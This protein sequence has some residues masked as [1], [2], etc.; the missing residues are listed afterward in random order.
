MIQ[1]LRTAWFR[2]QICYIV[3]FAVWGNFKTGMKCVIVFTGPS[4]TCC[5]FKALSCGIVNIIRE[6][7]GEAE[8][9]ETNKNWK[10]N[11]HT[12]LGY[13][14]VSETLFQ[15][16]FHSFKTHAVR[17]VLV[18]APAAKR[19]NALFVG[20]KWPGFQVCFSPGPIWCFRVSSQTSLVIELAGI[21]LNILPQI[22]G[23]VISILYTEIWRQQQRETYI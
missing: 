1:M 14:P 9:M 3:F 10:K 16:L 18:K 11:I 22:C 21:E 2:K 12:L 7:I 19:K 13:I 5:S 23:L 6:P 20:L 15:T 8:R 4:K 17:N